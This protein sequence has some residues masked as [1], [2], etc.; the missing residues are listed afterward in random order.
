MRTSGGSDRHLIDVCL[1]W[2]PSCH[3]CV[4]IEAEHS[5]YTPSSSRYVCF[6]SCSI[7]C[8]TASPSRLPQRVGRE[9]R[10][11]R[12]SDVVGAPWDASY[13][14]LSRFSQVSANV[15]LFLETCSRANAQPSFCDGDGADG[16]GPIRVERD[17]FGV[18]EFGDTLRFKGKHGIEK[19]KAF[20]LRGTAKDGR[21][22]HFICSAELTWGFALFRISDCRCQ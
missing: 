3:T 6:T 16:V 12:V 7:L 10:V 15:G 13:P 22:E 9:G 14:Q 19:G 8:A 1:T 11:D 20:L 18:D 2:L 21:L 17:A 5:S 4:Y